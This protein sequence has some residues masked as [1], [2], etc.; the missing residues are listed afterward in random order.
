MGMLGYHVTQIGYIF[1][2]ANDGYFSVLFFFF[3]CYVT[4]ALFY[5]YVSLF[6]TKYSLTMF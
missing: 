4:A 3:A 5:A 1:D 2:T 6:I